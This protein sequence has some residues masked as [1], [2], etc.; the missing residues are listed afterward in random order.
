MLALS[1]ALQ[2]LKP[3]TWRYSQVLEFLRGIK[4]FKLTRRNPPE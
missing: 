1:A 3:I 4:S 2:R